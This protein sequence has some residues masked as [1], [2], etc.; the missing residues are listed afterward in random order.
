MLL[1]LLSFRD[2]YLAE[3]LVYSPGGDRVVETVD[4]WPEIYDMCRKNHYSSGGQLLTFEDAIDDSVLKRL[5]RES[6]TVAPEERRKVSLVDACRTP[7]HL[8][9]W[10]GAL[11][12]APPDAEG[13]VASIRRS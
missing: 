5:V 11:L 12:G 9:G 3:W 13:V 2:G 8:Y 6:R 7:V 4:Q 10:D 1:W